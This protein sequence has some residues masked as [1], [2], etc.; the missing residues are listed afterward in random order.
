MF[1]QLS[2]AYTK[3]KR[4]YGGSTPGTNRDWDSFVFVP[5]TSVMN[6]QQNNQVVSGFITWDLPILRH[7]DSVLGKIAGG[8]QITANGSWSFLN[9][10]GTVT[11]GYDANA[12]NQGDDFGK[13][14]APINYVK[15]PINNPGSDL[16]YQWIDPSSFVYP[17]GTLNKTFSNVLTYDGLNV[18]DLPGSWNV[19]AGL[20]KNFRIKDATRLQLRIEAFNV[21]NHAN[22]NGPNLSVASSDFGKIY[23]KY[24]QG[25]RIQL[26]VRF[27]F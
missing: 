24:G 3:A 18:I 1:A 21:L 11:A 23:G 16:L 5:D 17:N 19:D 25:R 12:N 20:M 6:V 9:K 2:W 10:G 14:V 26:G 27:M 4:N 7:D 15:T 22:L 13:Q 8:W